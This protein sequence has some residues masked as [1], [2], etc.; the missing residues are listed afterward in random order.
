LRPPAARNCA[1]HAKFRDASASRNSHVWST[2]TAFRSGRLVLDGA[3][4][5]GEDGTGNAAAGDLA[6]NAADT[7]RRGAIGEQRNQL[8]CRGRMADVS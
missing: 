5:R 3:D 8:T 1:R 4:D 6:D 7:R 2:E